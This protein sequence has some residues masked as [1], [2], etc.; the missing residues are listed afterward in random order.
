MNE[1]SQISQ[2]TMKDDVPVGALAT[3]EAAPPPHPTPMP[4]QVIDFWTPRLLLVA[5]LYW[6][7]RTLRRASRGA[8]LSPADSHEP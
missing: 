7:G 3:D 2:M 8:T 1:R 6:I 4:T 5:L